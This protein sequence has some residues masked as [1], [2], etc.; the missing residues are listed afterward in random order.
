M[1]GQKLEEGR[2]RPP[3]QE[4]DDV[5]EDVG[6]LYEVVETAVSA[7]LECDDVTEDVGRLYKAEK[8]RASRRGIIPVLGQSDHNM[9]ST[10]SWEN[11]FQSSQEGHV[12]RPE[13][14]QSDLRAFPNE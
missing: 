5:T 10:R 11:L 4:S 9:K 13:Q 14:F 8:T 12:S 7:I 2:M 3:P 6:H 1:F